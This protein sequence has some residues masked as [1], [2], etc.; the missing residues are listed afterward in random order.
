MTCASPYCC[1]IVPEPLGVAQ[2]EV[3][4]PEPPVP[5][6]PL[7]TGVILLMQTLKVPARS[8]P[9]IC[10]CMSTGVPS[11]PVLV[12]LAGLDIGGI[13]QLGQVTSAKQTWPIQPLVK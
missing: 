11:V 6:P 1:E 9:G 10:S 5:G 4:P 12:H 13:D 8:P 3:P 7:V 2:A